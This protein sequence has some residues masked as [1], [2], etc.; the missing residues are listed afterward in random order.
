MIRITSSLSIAER[1]LTE[2]F[3]KATGPGGQNVNKLSTAVE[4]RF[5]AAN[6]PSLDQSTFE[7]L[8]QLAGRRMSDEGILIIRSQNYRTQERNRADAISRLVALI[9]RASIAP[10]ARRPTKPTAASK[11]RRRSTKSRRSYIKQLRRQR[12]ESD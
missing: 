10:K 3:M 12:I 5:D 4:L 1:E 9:R 8:K 2:R 11:L 7:R 6:S